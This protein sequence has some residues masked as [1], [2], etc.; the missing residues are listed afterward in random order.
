AVMLSGGIGITPLR[1]MIKY[2]LDKKLKI[3]ITLFYSNKVPEEI[4]YQKGLETFA[5]NRNFTLISTITEPEESKESWKG[6]IG[7]IDANLIKK[8]VKDFDNKIF[9][10]CGPPKMVDLM[11]NI[12]K[13][14][15]I[16]QDQIKIEHF[17]GY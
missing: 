16:P 4:L 3:K 11:Q 8:Y 1:S 17:F 12:L 14:M 13:E 9:Y 15:N 6:L 10:I 2:S 7:R 5:K